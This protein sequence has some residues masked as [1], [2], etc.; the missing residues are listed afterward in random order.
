MEG[1]VK[2]G[3]VFCLQLLPVRSGLHGARCYLLLSSES[4]R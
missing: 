3:A 4:L 2:E 1:L